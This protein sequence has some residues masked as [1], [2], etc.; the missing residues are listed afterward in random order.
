MVIRKFKFVM[1]V[2]IILIG[3]VAQKEGGS[4]YRYANGGNYFGTNP[5]FFPDGTKIVFG[6][7]RYGVGDI[8]TINIDGSELNRLTDMPAYEG[9]PK[10]SP[11]SKSIV[12][13]SERSSAD[14]GKIFIMNTDGSN[15]RQLTFGNGYDYGPS[16]SHDGTKIVFCR[17]MA[18]KSTEIF[19]MN[20]DGT[21]QIK[22]TNDQRLKDKPNFLRG[23]KKIRYTVFNLK[24][25]ESEIYEMNVDGT[26]AVL[27][28]R[29][30]K[31]AY[32]EAW[33]YDEENVVYISSHIT[34]YEID[35]NTRTE[36]MIMHSNGQNIRQLTN[37]RTYKSHP[38][39]SPDA[40]RIAFLS[41][42][43][44]GR[45]KGQIMIM[46]TDGSDLKTITNNY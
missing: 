36:V 45:G 1:L 22:L 46:N 25:Q 35:P 8:F 13:I 43:K 12:F 10:V 11:N 24:T 39:F 4:G 6:S 44:D 7:I 27:V 14:Y 40:K 33:S 31:Y 23:D 17:Q 29:I 2:T 30:P 21:R 20:V 16:F 19:I 32:D 15:Q 5:S 3:C 26:E 37:T 42:E 28:L 18:D 9:E 38:S 41:E 34:N